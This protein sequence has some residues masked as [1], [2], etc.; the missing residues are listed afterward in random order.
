MGIIQ[1]FC[2]GHVHC[3]A[4]V[5]INAVGSGFAP[6]QAQLFLNSKNKIEVIGILPDVAHGIQHDRA[7][8]AIVQIRRN[9]TG[10]RGKG[11]HLRNGCVANLDESS[12]MGLIFRPDV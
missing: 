6:A 11:R 10:L 4:I 5:W 7:G 2:R 8:D 12:G 3:N 1:L 9:Q